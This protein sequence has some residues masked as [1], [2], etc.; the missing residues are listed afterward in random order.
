MTTVFAK[1]VYTGTSILE[2]QLIAIENGRII[3]LTGKDGAHTSDKPDDA[4]ECLS[5]AFTDIQVNGGMN[6]NFT[7]K[8]DITTLTDIAGSCAALGTGF[9]LP[10]L[11]STT[12]ENIL[13]AIEAIKDFQSRYPAAGVLGI[14]LEGPFINPAKRGAH[15]T[16]WIRKP[17][18]AELEE[19]IRYGKGVL[20]LMTIAPE[21]FTKD[22]IDLLVS[23]GI[24]ISA[25]HSNA[26][27]EQ[28]MTGFHHG[29]QLVT[30]L[31]NAMSE[32]EPRSPG[33]VGAAFDTPYVATPLILDGHH[34]DFLAARIAYKLKRDK[35]FL[36]SDV[37]FA[38]EK[39]ESYEWGE[40]NA[41]LKG[42]QYINS[43]GHFAGSAISLGD[44]VRNAVLHVG[45]ALPEAISMVTERPA[46]AIHMDKFIGRIQVGYPAVF[47]IFDS[48]LRDFKTLRL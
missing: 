5:P 10:T 6:L 48:K 34:S 36:V 1:K 19:I 20:R 22:Q 11:L 16:S 18:D 38:G 32:F 28:A 13:K 26:T 27:Y 43:E 15:A 2:D 14:H 4:V 41:F 39:K 47:T 45:I 12:L 24:A 23:S 29:I 44:A 30:H 46:A 33:L 25:G 35:F 17:T 37:L 9:M 31:Y 40:F 42:D 3:S 7:E 21:V 8:P